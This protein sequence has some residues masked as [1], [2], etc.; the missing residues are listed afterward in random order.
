MAPRDRQT[1]KLMTAAGVAELLEIQVVLIYVSEGCIKMHSCRRSPEQV[2]V[3]LCKETEEFQQVNI[4][5][6]EEYFIGELPCVWRVT[7]GIKTL[8]QR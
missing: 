1:V 3:L 2:T 7:K 4:I 6:A 8:Y 5:P